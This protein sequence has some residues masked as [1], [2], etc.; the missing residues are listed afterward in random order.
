MASLDEEEYVLPDDHLK[1]LSSFSESSDHDAN[2]LDV[3]LKDQ[4]YYKILKAI[5][6]NVP[7]RPEISIIFDSFD[8]RN[9]GNHATKVSLLNLY[10]FVC[11]LAVSIVRE[12]KTEDMKTLFGNAATSFIQVI[13][14]FPAKQ[15]AREKFWAFVPLDWLKLIIT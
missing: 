10:S 3:S 6:P 14:T 5:E 7:S 8:I 11:S 13:N 15:G 12:G 2:D 9:E 1:T 4:A